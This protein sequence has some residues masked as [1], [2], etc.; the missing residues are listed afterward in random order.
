MCFYG[1]GFLGWEGAVPFFGVGFVLRYEF[2]A[3]QIPK[4]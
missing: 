4:S 1:N 3:Y 2:R